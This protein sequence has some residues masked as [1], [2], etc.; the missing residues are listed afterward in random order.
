MEADRVVKVGQVAALL[1][2]MRR[3]T[4]TLRDR[5]KV[6]A[7]VVACD[8]PTYEEASTLAQEMRLRDYRPA[9]MVAPADRFAA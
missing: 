4:A 7:M 9:L 1:Y 2:K 5:L 8:G 3:G 6:E